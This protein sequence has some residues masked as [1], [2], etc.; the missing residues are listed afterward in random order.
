MP[1]SGGL[2]SDLQFVLFGFVFGFW[3]LGF[4]F[5]FSPEK[6]FLLELLIF[7]I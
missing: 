3:V 6:V 5:F 1:S 2:G 7:P 4:W